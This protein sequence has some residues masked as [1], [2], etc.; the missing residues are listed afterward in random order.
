MD[1][2]LASAENEFVVMDADLLRTKA[3]AQRMERQKV[4]SAYYSVIRELVNE[5]Q[6]YLAAPA[7]GPWEPMRKVSSV[8]RGR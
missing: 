7:L 6:M 3:I 5:L 1:E 8:P 4:Q 2:R